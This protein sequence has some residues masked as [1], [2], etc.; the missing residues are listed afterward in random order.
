LAS[1]SITIAS[2]DYTATQQDIGV[3]EENQQKTKQLLA[4]PQERKILNQQPR[5]PSPSANPPPHQD[6]HT[7]PPKIPTVSSLASRSSFS[8]APLQASRPKIIKSSPSLSPFSGGL[9]L[10]NP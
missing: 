3:A 4:E 10:L 9:N 7:F 2:R 8:H 1:P 5:M 6:C